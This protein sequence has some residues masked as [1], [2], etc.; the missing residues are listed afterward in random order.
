MSSESRPPREVEVAIVGAGFGGLGAAIQ[1]QRAGIDDVVLLERS[2]EVGGTWS[3]N[4]YPGCQC[5][6]PSNLY[7]FSFAR[8]ADWTH[9]YPEQPQI[10]EYLRDVARRFKLTPKIRLGTELTEAAWDDDVQRWQIETTGG[11]LTARFLIGATG[12]L[13]EPVIPDLPGLDRFK[14]N[15]F[16]SARWDHDHDLAGK[17]VAVIGTGA[18][19][20][21]IVPRIQ[22]QVERLYVLQRTPPWVLPHAD[23]EIG[24]R[25]KRLYKLFP[26]A[27]R[28]SRYGVYWLRE[29]LGSGF[30]GFK[31]VL[32]LT[33]LNGRIHIRRKVK[34][35]EMRKKVTPGYRIGCKRI[36]LSD[37]W[38]P[39]LQTANTELVTE[40]LAEV[41]ENALKLGDG[42]EREV[43][44]IVFG[45]GFSPT[46]PPLA[47][48]LRGRD[49]R[50]LSEAWAETMSAYL[51]TAV[52]GF[53]NMFLLWGPNTNL[54][55]TS[56]VFMIE[57]QVRYVVQAVKAARRGTL[58][59]RRE[60][61][62][63]WHSEMQEQLSG[64]V[65]NTGGCASWYIDRSGQNPIM[66]PGQTFTFRRRT[67][68][69]DPAD[70]A[71][72]ATR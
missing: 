15:A 23:R 49:G 30:V 42:S 16:H 47:H 33:E 41:G 24:P 44:T 56:V 58:E 1:L 12:L 37:D 62:D 51:G 52:A 13:S 4:T 35:A 9:S 31:P 7:S 55:H 2:D 70:Y 48:R 39:A 50:T 34:D 63:R 6:V 69:F 32:W 3:A 57:S 59:V 36:L 71:L 45:T 53:P 21:Q 60:V 11:E 25:L 19:A 72:A 61:Q 17:R 66:W 20:I 14:G 8:K 43:D 38:Y 67:R 18:S 68:R 46:D 65:W 10:L 54:A 22:P 27:Q 28:L 26:P 40:P 29:A 64:S 5:D